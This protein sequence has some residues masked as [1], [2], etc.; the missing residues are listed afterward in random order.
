MKMK[1]LA[2]AAA[3][4]ALALTWATAASA[5]ITITLGQANISP[6]P[7]PYGTVDVTRTDDTHAN[8]TFTS[9]ISGSGGYKYYFVDGGSAA[10]NVNA[11]SWT[12]TGLTK[13]GSG[14]IAGGAAGNEDGF[15]SFN[16]TFNSSDS[17]GDR[18]HVISFT[19]VNTGATA[20][21]TD[22]SV[23]TPNASGFRVAAHIGV[24]QLSTNP[25]CTTDGG[26]FVTGFA[27]EGGGPIPEPATW[28]MM[29]MGFGGIGAMLRR[30]RTLA[31][32]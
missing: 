17:W 24:C 19:L 28:A 16:Q 8:I 6:F 3:A 25:N 13:D 23:L 7:A 30:R 15:G 18:S 11:S 2:A 26:A 27:T 31:F 4:S 5:T 21:L 12:F 9:D 20:W 22:S 14:A 29:I 1:L 32:A 10:V